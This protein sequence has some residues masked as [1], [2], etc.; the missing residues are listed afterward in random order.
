MRLLF[1]ADDC[2]ENPRESTKKISDLIKFQT[3]GWFQDIQTKTD[4]PSCHQQPKR[5]YHGGE[6]IHSVRVCVCVLP[7]RK[8]KYVEDI[9][10]TEFHHISIEFLKS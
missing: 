3:V 4:V 9:N 6:S 8:I 10:L 5:K 7:V 2:L 1:A